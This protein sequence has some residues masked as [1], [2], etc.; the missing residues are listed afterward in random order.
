MNLRHLIFTAI[1]LLTPLCHISSDAQ[2]V[3]SLINIL[4]AT[5]SDHQ[6]YDARKEATIEKIQKEKQRFAGDYEKEYLYNSKLIDAYTAYK[7][8]SVVKYLN[9]NL[10]LAQAHHDTYRINETRIRL[11]S[12][13]ASAGMYL[14]SINLISTIH[15]QSLHPSLLLGYYTACREAYGELGTY[16]H[17]RTSRDYYKAISKDYRD[18]MLAMLPHTSTRYYWEMESK[19]NDANQPLQALRIND[20]WLLQVRPDTRDYSIVCFFR[21]VDYGKLKNQRMEEY[22]LLKSAI[23][24]IRSAVKDQA[25]LWTL[26]NRLSN[27]GDVNRA[28][29]YIRYSWDE[30]K[31]FNAPLRNQ[32]TLSGLTAIDAIYQS[33]IENQ[34]VSLRIYLGITI[35]LTLLLVIMVYFLYRQMKKLSV[36]HRNL[37]EGNQ[38]LSVSNKIK[39]EYIGRFMSLCSF[40]L[41]KLESF[42][43][44][45]SRK[46]R[47]GQIAEY[48]SES[49]LRDM[50]EKDHAELLKNFDTAFLRLFPNFIEDFNKLLKPDQQVKISK[51]E[52]LNTELRIFALIRLGVDDSSKI[53]DFLHYSAN[54]IYNYRARAKKDSIVPREEFEMNVMRIGE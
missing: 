30:T 27:Q 54:T 6:Q 13:F 2:N 25:S 49:K 37:R 15:S 20:Q 38:K 33:K 8:D 43:N 22:W 4:D 19:Y 10:H 9:A 47:S 34:N 24:D 23:S 42:R 44:I 28:F 53:A 41:D 32:Q 46:S 16:S 31:F 51:E 18:S 11:I 21:S 35:A 14:E 52:L 50:K 36:A 45:I 26:A 12:T 48:L 39:E 17:D 29:R 1:I 40:Y 7:H 5:I 3:D